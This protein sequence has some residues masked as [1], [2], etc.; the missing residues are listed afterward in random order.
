MTEQEEILIPVDNAIDEFCAHLLSHSRTILSAKFGDG[1]S[2]FIQQLMQNEDANKMFTF[3][4]LYPVNYQVADN[5]DIFEL[6]KRDILVQ[7]V[8][9]KMIPTEYEVSDSVAFAFYMQNHGMGIVESLLSIVNEV[10]SAPSVVRAVLAGIKGLKFVSS[11]KDKLEIFK[12][13]GSKDKLICDFLD[14]MEGNGIY[15]SD[16]ITSIIKDCVTEYQEKTN[17][18]VVLFFEDMDR[19][20]PGHLFRIMNVLSAQMDYCYK[21]GFQPDYDGLEGNKF[22]VD[23]VVLVLDYMNLKN[24]FAHFYG[25]DTRMEGYISKFSNKGYFAYSLAEE[26][27]KYIGQIFNRETGLEKSI[28]DALIPI[29]MIRNKSLRQLCSAVD[30]T[31]S[32]IKRHFS[33]RTIDGNLSLHTG[34]LS[35]IVIMRR[36][37]MK[38]SEIID[39]LQRVIITHP[40]LM[41]YL[42][43]LVRKME[44]KDVKQVIIKNDNTSYSVIAFGQNLSDGTIEVTSIKYGGTD[45]DFFDIARFSSWLIKQVAI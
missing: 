36:L 22:G 5:K 18:R 32:Q 43:G 35:C 7:L 42:G 30:N 25:P 6:V 26:R 14:K 38:D 1:K 27:E 28:I 13:K 24:I 37:G 3:I 39:K 45:R 16:A 9:N 41:K 44:K 21:L 17:K 4:K 12:T 29:D 8:Y 2:Y 33:I 11:L 34:I 15:E 23:N 31:N 20:D 40:A 10:D 19:I